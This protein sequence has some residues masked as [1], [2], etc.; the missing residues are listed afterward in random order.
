[1]ADQGVDSISALSLEIIELFKK[2]E[3]PTTDSLNVGQESVIAK[4]HDESERFMLWTGNLGALHSSVDPRS[5]AYRVRNAPEVH[6]RATDLLQ[7]LEDL[8]GE[9]VKQY[10]TD[11]KVYSQ[12]PAAQ[13]LL[14]D[15]ALMLE[16]SDL[17]TSRECKDSWLIASI[18]DTIARLFKISTLLAKFTSTDRFAKAECARLPELDVRYDV[19]H[20]HDKFAACQAEHWLLDRL[21]TANTKRRQTII[22]CREHRERLAELPN[23]RKETTMILPVPGKVPTVQTHH[24]LTPK[25]Q[26]SRTSVILTAASTLKPMHTIPI[27][28]GFDDSRSFSTMATSL[29]SSPRHTLKVPGLADVGK[30]S[31]PFECP[32]CYTMQRFNGLLSWR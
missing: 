22:Y 2:V 6:R 25:T 15:E 23:I 8:L 5:L 16:L 11:S 26:S 29:A 9:G 14:D 1:M 31:Q 17:A 28:D 18:S 24:K 7:E 21:G 32:Y 20:M 19:A 4:L 10:T 3:V 30:V 13:D 27:D 12:R